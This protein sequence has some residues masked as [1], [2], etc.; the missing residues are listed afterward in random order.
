MAEE[1]AVTPNRLLASAG[2]ALI[3]VG[4]LVLF[5]DANS[6][7]GFIGVVFVILGTSAV[8]ASRVE[9]ARQLAV[10]A[11]LL[12]V[13]LA[14]LAFNTD[15][16]TWTAG[17]VITVLGALSML[18]YSATGTP[19]KVLVIVILA[20]A[21]V[22]AT[23]YGMNKL[24]DKVENATNST[25]GQD[26]LVSFGLGRE[27]ETSSRII[28]VCNPRRARLQAR[29]T[30][31]TTRL[32][33]I[34]VENGRGR[35]VD[36]ENRE[37]AISPADRP[38]VLSTNV[39]GDLT[40]V[41]CSEQEDDGAQSSDGGVDNAEAT[42]PPGVTGRFPADQLT[43]TAELTGATGVRLVVAADP[44]SPDEVASGTYCGEVT[45]ERNGAPYQ[46]FTIAVTID[47][48]RGWALGY[49]VAW[50]FMGALAGVFIRFLNDP[51]SKLVGPYRRLRSLQRWA[52]GTLPGR[53][54]DEAKQLLDDIKDA[55]SFFDVAAAEALL[56]QLEGI[57]SRPTADQADGIS[58]LSKHAEGGLA[59]GDK[60]K[61]D[62]GY[63]FVLYRFYWP[64]ALVTLVVGIVA[65]GAVSR[66]V[67]N[68]A[69][70]GTLRDWTGLLLFGLA[71]QVTATT[72]AESL[73]RLLPSASSS[74]T[75][76]PAATPPSL[77]PPAADGAKAAPGGS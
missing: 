53:T 76:R 65:I 23:V 37:P 44:M 38:G 36:P 60:K 35:C 29:G 75:A 28:D 67:E 4:V 25:A 56:Q 33:G 30:P 32:A 13:G 55:L 54:Q 69:F 63:T 45:V 50:L 77:P 1:Q 21:G 61:G 59:R 31:E 57:R 22:A 72:L 15:H 66:Y 17:A 20:G 10:G 40:E 74:S 46:T 5:M 47:D 3:A 7:A 58:E 2:I 14:A 73:G 51:I 43:P 6:T 16:G 12:V 9:R 49:A 41:A 18:V 8:M 42:S 24:A 64:L 39:L 70:A 52:D 27:P 26:L 19:G 68:N 62:D 11:V 48:R 71:A 34:V